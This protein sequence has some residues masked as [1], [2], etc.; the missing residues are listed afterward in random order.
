VSQEPWRLRVVW[1]VTRELELLDGIHGSGG[2][3]TDP[4]V[5]F[6]LLAAHCKA[7]SY[8]R[9]NAHGHGQDGVLDQ[10]CQGTRRHPTGVRL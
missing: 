2:A 9:G 3:A 5:M 4:F 10:G 6:G 1:G 7:S 8:A